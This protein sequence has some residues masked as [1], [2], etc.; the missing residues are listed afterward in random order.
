MDTIKADDNI[1][2]VVAA[3]ERREILSQKTMEFKKMLNNKE[4]FIFEHRIMIEEPLTLQG[5]GEQFK[6]SRERVRQ[7]E[8]R[9]IRKFNNKFE[10][11]FRRLDF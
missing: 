7:L 3:K 4:L 11:E 2:E 1:E 5:I 6:I 10:S 9:V 8:S